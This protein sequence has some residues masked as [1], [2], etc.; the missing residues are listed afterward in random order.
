MPRILTTSP[1]LQTEF[2]KYQ[3]Q[4]DKDQFA[5]SCGISLIEASPGFAKAR[6]EIRD[7]HMNSVGIL[8]GGALFTLADFTFAV[9]SNAHGKVALGINAEIS[10]FKAVASGTVTA[11]AREISFHNRLATYLIDIV[12]EK[13]ELIAHFKGTVY[14]K[15]EILDFC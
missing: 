9:A 10:F 8:H 4:F 14:R 2:S 13:G 1:G 15:S 12:N 3:R 5:R 7:I 11:T 6:M